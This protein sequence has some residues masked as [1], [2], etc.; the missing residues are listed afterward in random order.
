MKTMLQVA[1]GAMSCAMIMSAGNTARADAIVDLSG[2]DAN[3]GALSLS[4]GSYSLWNLLGGGGTTSGTVVPGAPGGTTTNFGG[5]STFTPTGDNAKNAILRYYLVVSNGT[6]NSVVSLGEIDPNF[7]GTLSSGNYVLQSN[8]STLVFQDL[9]A[10]AS[11]RDLSNVTNIKL[12]AVPALLSTP[13]PATPST[14]VQLGG[15]VTKPGSYTAS[16]L[17]TD[18]TPATVETVNGDI[19]T[20][21][22]LYTFLDPDQNNILNQYV[23]IGAT[24][25]YEVV[26][27]LA[28]VDPALGGTCGDLLPYADTNHNFPADGVARDILPCDTAFAHGRWDSDIN[29][30]QV[31]SV[32]EPGSLAMVLAGLAILPLAR[33]RRG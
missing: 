25:G 17:A 21:V 15:N 26:L 24:D 30:I 28:E 16:N 31:N 14:A 2:S 5:I 20:G 9:N 32:P 6:Q 8:G 11:G 3:A 19:Y 29:G 23:A 12:V 18:F 4:A 7:V 22:P 13:D 33:R 10:G 27:S 1:V